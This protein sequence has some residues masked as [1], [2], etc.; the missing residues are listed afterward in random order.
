MKFHIFINNFFQSVQRFYASIIPPQANLKILSL[1]SNMGQKKTVGFVTQLIV[2]VKSQQF[3]VV[4]YF[5]HNEIF[6][7]FLSSLYSNV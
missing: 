3:V 7:I 5:Q 2:H 4:G 1:L 6:L